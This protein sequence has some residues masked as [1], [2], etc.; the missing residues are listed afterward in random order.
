MVLFWLTRSELRTDLSRTIVAFAIGEKSIYAEVQL[1]W[2]RDAAIRERRPDL[3]G[4]QRRSGAWPEASHL[5][6]QAGV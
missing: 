5:S 3:P 1:L 6:A 4:L 2:K